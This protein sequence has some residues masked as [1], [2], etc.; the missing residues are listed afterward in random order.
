MYFNTKSYLKNTRN[1]TDKHALSY[2]L[3]KEPGFCLIRDSGSWSVEGS[4]K[5]DQTQ[6]SATYKPNKT[7]PNPITCIFLSTNLFISFC[8]LANYLNEPAD[9]R[10]VTILVS[11]HVSQFCGHGL[12]NFN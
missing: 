1:H 3:S 7:M 5:T 11:L 8:C 12:N 6:S 2:K 10:N 4:L 9:K